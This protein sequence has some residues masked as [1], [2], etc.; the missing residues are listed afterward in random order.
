LG[1]ASSTDGENIDERLHNPAYTPRES[2]ELPNG[3]PVIA[4]MSG[5]GYGGIEDPRLTKIGNTIYLTYVAFDGCNPP[6]VALSSIDVENFVNKRFTWSKPKLIS[7]PGV[8]DKNAVIFPEKIHGKYVIMHR[9]FPNILVDFVD[10]LLFEN[11]Y[12]KGEYKISPRQDYW[13]SRKIGAGAPPIKTDKG[14]LLIY[15]AV[16]DRDASQYKIGA[17]L[18]DLENPLKILYWSRKPII[19][20]DMWYDNVGHK[21]GVVYPCGAVI[22]NNN[23]IVYYGG[24]DT[25]VCAAKQNINEFLDLLVASSKVWPDK[26]IYPVPLR[27]V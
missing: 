17:M 3:K 4:Y 18:L 5:G 26:T 22:K 20:P 16:D 21:S 23:L 9:I 13:D 7:K 2:F 12:L 6:R 25:V 27:K 15:H 1:Y 14:W 10:D 11:T 19:I 24:A 8:V